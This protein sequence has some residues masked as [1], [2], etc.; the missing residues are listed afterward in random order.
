MVQQLHELAGD[1]PLVYLLTYWAVDDGVLHAWVVPEDVAFDAFGKLPANRSGEH[2]TV[3]VSTDDHQLKNA[4]FAP[5]FA[6]FYVSSPLTEEEIAKLQEAI[7]TDDLIKQERLEA[8]ATQE[9][10]SDEGAN[11]DDDEV[12][13]D[14][15]DGDV[16]PGY[17]DE[18]VAFLLDLPAHVEDAAWHEKN[19]KRYQTVLRDPSQNLVEELRAIYIQQLSPVVAGGKRHLSI[20]K[21]NDYGKGGYHDHYW[22]A[23]YDPAAGSKTKSVQL[24]EVSRQRGS[25]AIRFFDGEL[26]RS[27]SG[28]PADSVA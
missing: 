19:K 5:S 1:R 18:T 21:K 24:F 20:L 26:L 28:A 8:D 9:V 4:P 16:S 3:E 11:H 14:E 13:D 17:M 7:N 2:K 27:V 12:G 23:F 22:F 6:P 15:W 10:A 25:L